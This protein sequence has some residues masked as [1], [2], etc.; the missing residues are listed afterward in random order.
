MRQRPFCIPS[1]AHV[2]SGLAIV[3]G[4]RV[5]RLIQVEEIEAL[6]LRLPSVLELQEPQPAAFIAR[7]ARWMDVLEPAL[8]AVHAHQAGRIAVLRSGLIIARYTAVR[9]ASEPQAQLTRV[10]RLAV[11]ASMALAEAAGLAAAIVD[12][13]RPRFDEADRRLTDLLARARSAQV[14]PT[15]EP[16]ITIHDRLAEVRQAIAHRGDLERAYVDVEG[17][18]GSDDA[19]LML[20]RA[21]ASRASAGVADGR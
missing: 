6:L 13:S 15:G 10:R 11:E 2:H 12:D 20:G 19:L 4:G 14:L 7:A 16:L 1:A 21:L 17:L 18:V 9:D 3:N 8:V 5:V